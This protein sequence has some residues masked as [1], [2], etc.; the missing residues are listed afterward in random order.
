MPHSHSVLEIFDIFELFLQYTSAFGY[1][2]PS[3]A[4][5]YDAGCPGGGASGGGRHVGCLRWGAG[6]VGVSPVGVLLVEVPLVGA[7]VGY[8]GGGPCSGGGPSSASSIIPTG[9]SSIMNTSL[10][11]SSE[12]TSEVA[13]GTLLSPLQS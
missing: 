1:P 6:R 13:V 5:S 8:P 3:P 10:L 7:P 9:R 12:S 4:A 2:C 11:L